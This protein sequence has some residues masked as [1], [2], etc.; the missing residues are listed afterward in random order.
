MHSVYACTYAYGV[1]MHT[2]CVTIFPFHSQTF[3]EHILTEQYSQRKGK[4]YT[5]YKV[6]W[7]TKENKFC[8]SRSF[9]KKTQSKNLLFESLKFKYPP[10]KALTILHATT[11][12][13][14]NHSVWGLQALEWFIKQLMEFLILKDFAAGN[15]WTN[16]KN[17]NALT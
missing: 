12:N 8:L 17:I 16:H 10:C 3:T 1:N 11:I 13:I 15:I 5:I 2:V 7:E 14:N 4:I 9:L 6:F